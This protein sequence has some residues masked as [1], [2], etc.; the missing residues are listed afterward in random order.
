MQ[1]TYKESRRSFL[2]GA[3]LFGVLFALFLAAAPASAQIDPGMK[4]WAVV[5]GTWD[6][7]AA[8][9]VAW[10]DLDTWK[11]VTKIDGSISAFDPEP[12][13]WIP[14]AGD[15]DGDGIDTIQMFNPQSWKLVAAEEGPVK[16]EFDPEPQPWVPVAGDWDGRGID[17]VRV[18]DLRD[19]SVHKLEEGPASVE[20]YDPEPQPWMPVAGDWDGKGIDSIAWV[21]PEGAF[22]AWQAVAGDW[23][24]KG[25]DT[26][27]GVHSATGELVRAEGAATAATAASLGSSGG[28]YTYSKNQVDIVKVFYGKDGSVIVIHIKMHEQWTCCAIDVNHTQYVCGMKLVVG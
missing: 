28:C 26:V 19:Q 16:A 3:C 9:S 4:G 25:I 24:G 12:Q 13:P 5:T 15:W 1:P 10:V 21:H 17:T 6:K 18:V 22:S 14:V 27:A 11:L 8:D 23:D 2:A 20:R 7:G